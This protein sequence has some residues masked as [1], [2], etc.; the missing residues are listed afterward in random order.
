VRWQP[1]IFYLNLLVAVIFIIVLWI[2]IGILM[3]II[4]NIGIIAQ[5]SDKAYQCELINGKFQAYLVL[6]IDDSVTKNYLTKNYHD[7]SYTCDSL[8]YNLK[9]YDGVQFSNALVCKKNDLGGTKLCNRYVFASPNS[10]SFWSTICACMLNQYIS[11]NDYDYLRGTM[12]LFHYISLPWT[13]GI[14]IVVS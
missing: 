2:C 1:D 4:A 11:T 3:I 10:T 6:T 7:P 5:K 12:S 9:R 13:G 8:N 14:W